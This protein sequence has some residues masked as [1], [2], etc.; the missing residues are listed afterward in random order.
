[1]C[2]GVS[3]LT[4]FVHMD[5]SVPTMSLFL[6]LNI[7]GMRSCLHRQS[8]RALKNR[9]KAY[10]GFSGDDVLHTQKWDTS[11]TDHYRCTQDH[12]NTVTDD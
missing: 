10:P 12:L 1:M 2:L 8:F 7:F 6:V 9:I 5:L 3:V 4:D 11:K